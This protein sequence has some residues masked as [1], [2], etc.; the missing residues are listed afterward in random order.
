M[1]TIPKVTRVRVPLEDERHVARRK[2]NDQIPFSEPLHPG[3]T[4]GYRDFNKDSLKG[5]MIPFRSP[6]PRLSRG[7]QDGPLMSPYRESRR[8]LESVE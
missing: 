1:N 8:N 2:T 4:L 7:L 5:C 3:A 6:L